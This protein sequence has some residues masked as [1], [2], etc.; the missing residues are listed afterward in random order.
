MKL[1][2]KKARYSLTYPEFFLEKLRDILEFFETILPPLV[3]LHVITNHSK[4]S[5]LYHY[6]LLSVKNTSAKV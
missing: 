4:V 3:P 2:P 5:L 6:S 1:L